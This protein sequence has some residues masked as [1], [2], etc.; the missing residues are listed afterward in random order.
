[1]AMPKD[2]E[3]LDLEHFDSGKVGKSPSRKFQRKKNAAKRNA[4]ENEVVNSF[5][6][7]RN[8]TRR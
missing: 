6:F 7:T 3:L 5:S 1:M 2:M 8:G 4:V